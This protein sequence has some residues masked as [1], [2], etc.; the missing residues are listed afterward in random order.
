M[1]IVKA[2]I[3]RLFA[4]LPY[5]VG[6]P[7]YYRL[8]R[9]VG[10]LRQL[11]P[12]DRFEGGL[13]IGRQIRAHGGRVAGLKLLE[14]GT[15]WRL[16]T[17]V[18]LWLQGADVISVDLYPLLKDELVEEDL[19]VL[20]REEARV[21]ALFAPG[22]LDESRWQTLLRWVA[23][24]GAVEDSWRGWPGLR[25]AAPRD[26]GDLRD[27]ADG[28]LDGV[29][30]FNVLEHVPPE[31]ILRL[32]RES[33]RLIQR[34]GWQVHLVDHSDHFAQVDAQL[35]SVHF[36]RYSPWIWQLLAGH[37]LAYCNRLRSRQVA[38]LF[39]QG[40]FQV[41]S[42]QPWV[43]VEAAEGIRQGTQPLWGPFAAMEAE[44]VATARTWYVLRPVPDGPPSGAL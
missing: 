30:S 36:L 42:R 35:S 12:F 19:R 8:Q 27:F 18:A 34:E 2:I 11:D 25:V 39:E 5:R 43:D 23:S 10:R 20:A 29:F 6:E 3:Q 4:L 13:E 22:E 1:W 37:R 41:V 44:E 38:E 17:P 31:Q 40:G 21:R 26:A 33:R 24:A 28:S 32:V 7:L 9:R 15:G 14:I 16:N